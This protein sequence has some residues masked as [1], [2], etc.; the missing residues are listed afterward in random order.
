MHGTMRN[1]YEI[2]VR[3]CKRMT[4]WA[5][6][7]ACMGT[8]INAYEILVRK[9]KRRTRWAV[10]VAC[11]GRLEMCMKLQSENVKEGPDRQDM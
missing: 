3:K 6:Y 5:R 7:I 2:L 8:M 11:M 10:Y 4:R 1:A 9:C